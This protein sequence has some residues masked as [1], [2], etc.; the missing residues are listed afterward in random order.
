MV[1]A[2]V[3]LDKRH[4]TALWSELHCFTRNIDHVLLAAP[5]WSEP[6]IR[7]L[8]VE[9][10]QKLPQFASNKVS[11]SAKFF[12]N[13]RYDVGLWCD[14]L[15]TL[16]G[17]EYDD[18]V[19]LND[20]LFALREFSGVLDTLREE[21]LR[22]TSLSYSARDPDGI[23]L[24]SVFR[25]FDKKGLS[26]FMNHSCVPA[27]HRFFCHLEKS[28]RDIKRCI[29]EHH[30]IAIARLFPPDEVKGLYASDVPEEMWMEHKPYATWTVHV[31]Y[32]KEVLVSKMNFPAAKV[33]KRDMIKT[34]KNPLIQNCTRLFDRYIL[35]GFNFSAGVRTI[36]K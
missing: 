29:T 30:E 13:D 23:W 12:V 8:L 1:L 34:M 2:A 5:L 25:G 9:V 24:E 11:I 16:H 31:P 17:D 10:K 19:L 14:G 32:W 28:S 15:K 21:N 4:V 35:E 6:I 22:M 33:T 27:N 7:E 18:V 3:P 26:T 20:S 36:V